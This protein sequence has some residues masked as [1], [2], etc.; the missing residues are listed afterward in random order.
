MS[1]LRDMRTNRRKIIGYAM[2]A[3]AE[4]LQENGLLLRLKYTDI[5]CVLINSVLVCH[6]DSTAT[7]EVACYRKVQK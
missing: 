6:F 3:R 4:L 1:M 7:C 5:L 2:L